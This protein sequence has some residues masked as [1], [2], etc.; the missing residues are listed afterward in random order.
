MATTELICKRCSRQGSRGFRPADTGGGMVCTS[1]Q[2]CDSRVQEA[3]DAVGITRKDWVRNG[4]EEHS[5]KLDGEKVP[6]VT[7]LLGDGLPK[8][9]LVG[10]GINKVS[11]YASEHLDEL[12]AMRGMGTEAVFASLRQA[13]YKERDDAGARG[14]QLHKWAELLMRGEEVPVG[15]DMLPWVRAVA[16]YLDDYNPATVLQETAVGSRK[17]RYAG[18]FDDVSDFPEGWAKFCSKPDC[19][20]TRK[21]VDYKSSRGV[22]AETVLQ[23]AGYANPENVFKTPEGEERTVG[24]LGLCDEGYVVHIRPE[25]YEV[26]PCYIG[27]EALQ[28]F[29]RVAWLARFR[30]KGGQLDGWLGDPLPHPLRK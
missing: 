3:R 16:D 8:P 30:A 25:G 28:A 15:P 6:G 21:I 13:P 22:Y 19:E 11:R 24:S 29:V 17:W 14:T 5:Y 27:P 18:S 12:W 4:K 7:T 1:T 20:H 10:W 2:A 23:L 9:F 26:V